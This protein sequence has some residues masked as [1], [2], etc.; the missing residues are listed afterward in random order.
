[1]EFFHFGIFWDDSNFD[2]LYQC[3]PYFS[4]FTLNLLEI[5]DQ[6]ETTYTTG[7][8]V[9]LSCVFDF[10]KGGTGP[11]SVTWSG[12]DSLTVTDEYTIDLGKLLSLYRPY[13][14]RF[15]S[16]VPYVS[17]SVLVWSLL[18]IAPSDQIDQEVIVYLFQTTFFGLPPNPF[19]TDVNSR[20]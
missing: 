12:I 1:M 14:V 2:L 16:F 6:S 19:F 11:T 13:L 5:T 15:V 4:E 10:T 17:I 18:V 7:D 3:I 20:V 9:V 8:N